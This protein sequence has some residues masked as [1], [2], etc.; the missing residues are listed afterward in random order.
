MVK[1]VIWKSYLFIFKKK[2]ENSRYIITDTYVITIHKSKKYNV[3]CVLIHILVRSAQYL[4]RKEEKIEKTNKL[5]D[6]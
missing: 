3:T 2:G 1:F 6:A 4:I 5:A